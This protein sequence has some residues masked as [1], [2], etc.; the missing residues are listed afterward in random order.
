MSV[1]G[2]A[3]CVLFVVLSV[4]KVLDPEWSAYARALPLVLK[5]PYTV[6]ENRLSRSDEIKVGLTKYVLILGSMAVGLSGVAVWLLWVV[7]WWLIAYCVFASAW[8]RVYTLRDPEAEQAL[9][10]AAERRA[11]QAEMTA[12]YQAQQQLEA[13]RRE[14]AQR[15]F[16]GR[17]QLEKL[18]IAAVLDEPESPMSRFYVT[19]TFTEYGDPLT[20]FRER[21]APLTDVNLR[22]LLEQSGAV[23]YDP[24]KTIDVEPASAADEAAPEQL[25]S[26]FSEITTPPKPRLEAL[27]RVREEAAG[28]PVKDVGPSDLPRVEGCIAAHLW[29]KLRTDW[30]DV[31][32]SPVAKAQGGVTPP[33]GR[34]VPEQFVLSEA[35]LEATLGG[36]PAG[37]KAWRYKGKS[38]PG[39]LLL[40]LETA[41]RHPGLYAWLR[42][43]E[44]RDPLLDLETARDDLEA[45]GLDLSVDDIAYGGGPVGGWRPPTLALT[46]M[47]WIVAIGYV[48]AGEATTS[49]GVKEPL[50]KIDL[51]VVW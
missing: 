31:I 37:L 28:S 14:Q 42:Q 6:S 34:Y 10:R 18:G 15:A 49:R 43:P 1:V 30:H 41:E 23:P 7:G 35:L 39:L 50:R 8:D 45:L 25:D 12:Y 4:R 2:L 46:E 16:E 24:A 13:E 3:Y 22:E 48:P 33:R 17:R 44:N 36:R 26:L 47:A 5:T 19:K 51:P 29:E 9:V 20:P 27:S 40:D 38:V 21:F 32:D 11:Q